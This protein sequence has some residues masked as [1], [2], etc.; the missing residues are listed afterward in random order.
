ML[1]YITVIIKNELKILYLL[2]F[3][4]LEKINKVL[5]ILYFFF[6]LLS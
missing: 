1:M 2:I 4:I 6:E 5:Y 3:Q